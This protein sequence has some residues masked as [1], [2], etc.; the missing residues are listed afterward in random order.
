MNLIKKI[1]TT[2]AA[3]V[4][5]VWYFNREKH[6]TSLRKNKHTENDVKEMKEEDEKKR[7]TEA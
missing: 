4:T 7:Q 1:R 6:A 2:A 5:T 3:A